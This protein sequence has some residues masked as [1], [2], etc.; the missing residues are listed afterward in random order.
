MTSYYDDM[1]IDVNAMREALRRSEM[2]AY[3]RFKP[4]RESIEKSIKSQ[5][6]WLNDLLPCPMCGKAPKL[7]VVSTEG[8]YSGTARVVLHL[9]CNHDGGSCRTEGYWNTHGFDVQIRNPEVPDYIVS[10]LVSTWNQRPS[11]QDKDPATGLRPC[12]FCGNKPKQMSGGNPFGM[13]PEVSC[14]SAVWVVCSANTDADAKK[15]WNTRADKKGFFS[16][17]FG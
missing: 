11:N 14:R 15:A 5:A 10:N 8:K 17:L 7:V 2:E 16:R 6:T 9:E 13:R 1:P 3:E 12:P 4:I